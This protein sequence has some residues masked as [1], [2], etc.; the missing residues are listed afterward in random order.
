MATPTLAV[1]GTAPS[2]RGKGLRSARSTFSPMRV[3]SS[4]WCRPGEDEDEGVGLEP[5]GGVALAHAVGEAAG[6][7]AQ[8]TVGQGTAQARVERGEAVDVHVHDAHAGPVA[9]GLRDGDGETVGEEEGAREAGERVAVHVVGRGRPVVHDLAHQDLHRGPAAV[10]D[11]R[12]GALDL[13]GRAVGAAH[14]GRETDAGG[15][16]RRGARR[17]L[18]HL[19]P[20]VGVEEVGQRAA[21][22]RGRG[23]QPEQLPQ[24]GVGED[25]APGGLDHDGVGGRGGQPLVALLALAEGLGGSTAFGQVAQGELQPPVR[26]APRAHLD[27]ERGGP[28]AAEAEG[29]GQTPPRR[30]DQQPRRVVHGLVGLDEVG[31]RRA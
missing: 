11:G 25:D 28:G 10:G 14:A 6:H 30:Q 12:G 26:E 16:R 3:A 1:R 29:A 19:E 31:E 7:A 17:R 23:L 9:V 27:L 24:R 13:G 20:L 21:G 8:H 2:V 4:P 5:G 22:H 18:R 15:A